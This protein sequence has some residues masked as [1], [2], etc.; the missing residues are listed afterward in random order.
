MTTSWKWRRLQQ[1]R[2]P[3]E[4]HL[5]RHPLQSA[6]V[7]SRDYLELTLT[8]REL[9]TLLSTLEE[10]LVEQLN[11]EL[12]ERE[13]ELLEL[14]VEMIG[15]VLDQPVTPQRVARLFHH[16][17]EI[18]EQLDLQALTERLKRAR[19]ERSLQRL[20]CEPIPLPELEKGYYSILRALFQSRVPATELSHWLRRIKRNIERQWRCYRVPASANPA[21]ELLKEG[22]RDLSHGLSL[23]S[24]SHRRGCSQL[25]KE[26]FD[27]ILRGNQSLIRAEK[28][29]ET[30]PA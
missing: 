7:A 23:L 5:G 16:L 10:E 21:D 26:G 13:I 15:R 8:E 22:Y 17:T 9:V 6:R 27:S 29:A 4:T 25:R 18:E 14:A 11:G 28:L 2:Q 30:L 12:G 20:L 24:E 19:Q 1:Q 3:A